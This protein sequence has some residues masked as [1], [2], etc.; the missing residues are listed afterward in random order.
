MQITV[1]TC[2]KI[3][4]VFQLSNSEILGSNPS[5]GIDVLVFCMGVFVLSRACKTLCD[6]LTPSSRL[7][8]SC[9]VCTNKI[10]KLES[11]RPC[12][13]SCLKNVSC[14]GK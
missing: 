1:T 11:G 12:L 5:Y 13:N 3:G 8:G 9:E 4:I 2:S 6:R 7:E 10:Y 14:C